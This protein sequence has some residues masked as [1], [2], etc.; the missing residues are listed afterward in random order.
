VQE[1][2]LPALDI[3]VPEEVQLVVD[4]PALGEAVLV[5]RSPVPEEV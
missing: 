4:I 3:L 1:E 2:A 5:V